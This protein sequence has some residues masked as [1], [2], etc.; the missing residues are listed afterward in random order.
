MPSHQLPHTLALSGPKRA[1][2]N[3]E[4]MFLEKQAIFLQYFAQDNF[5]PLPFMH[6]MPFLTYGNKGIEHGLSYLW[7]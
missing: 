2:D 4:Q 6:F 1:E 7:Q 3:F 5:V